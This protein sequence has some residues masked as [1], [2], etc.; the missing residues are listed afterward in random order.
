MKTK[1]LEEILEDLPRYKPEIFPRRKSSKKHRFVR[2][3]LSPSE[4][5]TLVALTGYSEEQIRLNQHE[6][7]R[8][9]ICAFYTSV[10]GSNNSKKSVLKEC[11]PEKR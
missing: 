10:F 5:E 6:I 7:K 9:N 11:L 8:L 3:E 4:M 1:V 2:T